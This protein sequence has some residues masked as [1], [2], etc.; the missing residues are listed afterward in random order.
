MLTNIDLEELC[1]H[2]KIPLRFCGMK[3]ELPSK[4]GS[5]DGNYIINLQSSFQGEG[6]HWTALNVSGNSAAFFDSY[7]APPSIEIE[8]FCKRNKKTLAFNNWIV[9]DLKSEN[10]GSFC[11]A[12]LLFLN[13]SSC[14]CS[15]TKKM[16]EFVNGF[17][18]NTKKN[19]SI[20][21]S[22]F[23]ELGDKHPPRQI[24]RL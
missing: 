6:T 16:N 23:H 11:L 7:G 5:S 18:D 22:F 19:D 21:A 17:N 15:N 2:Y 1:K 10:C 4:K 24:L 9:Q 3:D 14:G 20:L 12:F 8:Q 13:R